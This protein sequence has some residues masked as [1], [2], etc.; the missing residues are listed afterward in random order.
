MPKFIPFTAHVRV[1]PSR[2]NGKR[3]E[4]IRD[5]QKIATLVYTELDADADLSIASPGGG[6]HQS[7]R[8]LSGWSGATNATAVKPQIGQ[9]PAQLMIT[10]FLSST[11][12][13]EPVHPNKP[14]LHTGSYQEGVGGDHGWSANPTSTADGYA[15]SLKTKVDAAVN[16]VLGGSAD[17]NI[18]R[19]DVAGIIYGDGGYHFPT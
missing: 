17:W 15:T 6:Q 14:V 1:V 9:N 3:F 5:L 11:D 12:N 10:G 19:L 13:N 8:G 2:G 16:A 7:Y 4:Y 18:F